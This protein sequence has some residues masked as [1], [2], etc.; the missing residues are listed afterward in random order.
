M[1][2]ILGIN[3]N[4][5]SFS[6]LVGLFRLITGR[7]AAK[8]RICCS[9]A[10]R[11]SVV[12]TSFPMVEQDKPFEAYEARGDYYISSAWRRECRGGEVVYI[13]SPLI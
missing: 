6:T 5:R 2:G 11:L 10:S 3:I 9:S 8:E 7:F 12:N 4:F 13:S 1:T